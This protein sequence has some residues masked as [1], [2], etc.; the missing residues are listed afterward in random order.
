MARFGFSQFGSGARFGTVDAQPHSSMRDLASF[1]RNPFDDPRISTIRLI[2]FT[3]DHIQ[4]MIANNASGEL[5]GRITATSDALDQVADCFTDDQTRLGLRK[6]RKQ[7]KDNFRE[8]TL[9]PGIERIEAGLIAAFSSS[10]PVLLE[11]LPK[12]RSIFTSCRDDELDIHLQTLI[13]AVTA[14]AA[15]L[16]PALVTL[17]TT[18]KTDWTTL[19][20]ASE[21]STGAKTTTEQG[22]RLARENLQLML[23][24]NLL[25]LAEMFPREPDRLSLYMQQH[26]LEVPTSS[27]SEDP[28]PTP[29]N[30]AP[31]GNG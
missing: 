9:P 8:Q 17:A 14:H 31:P 12:G 22:K 30:P 3:T 2:T 25:K 23:F 27:D 11:A 18:L 1:L 10:S 19:H 15:S 26:L 5:S 4:R 20:A 21:S 24:L 29:P 7:A 13:N 28:P 6:A 16:A